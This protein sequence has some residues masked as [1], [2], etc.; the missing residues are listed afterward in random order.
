MADTWEK[1][2][3]SDSWDA[4]KDKEIVGV[5]VSKEENVGPNESMLYTIE[6]EDGEQV[7]VWGSSVLNSR[8]KQVYTGSEVKIVYKGRE[9]NPKT[10]R[11]YK[12]YE[13]YTKG[14]TLAEEFEKELED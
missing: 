3:M 12:M 6:T 8:M 4:E 10:G 13:V 11:E 2:E 1:V 9:E 5:L 14:N 7:G